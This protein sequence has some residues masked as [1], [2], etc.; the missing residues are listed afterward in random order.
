MRRS[1]L[2]MTAL[3]GAGLAWAQVRDL[4]PNQT[5]L[6]AQVLGSAQVEVYVNG[7]LVPPGR[8]NGFAWQDVSR[9]VRFG[10]NE[11]RFVSS[12]PAT[13]TLTVSFAEQPGRFRQVQQFSTFGQS[14]AQ[15]RQAGAQTFTFNLPDPRA[16][17][18][19]NAGSA[20]GQVWMR[21]GSAYPVKAYVNGTFVG[22][23]SRELRLGLDITPFTRR[24]DNVLRLSGTRAE[25]S[26]VVTLL[27]EPSKNQ[28]QTLF[29]K[30]EWPEPANAPLSSQITFTRP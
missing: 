26:V 19:A 27:Y 9:L 4:R 30:V 22:E 16:A 11:V 21:V 14:E 25:G 23:V 3:A 10:P 8:S 1:V 15:M 20:A 6:R 28:F 7:K 17:G 12:A 2:V 29:Q 18:K 5:I 13:V 24:G